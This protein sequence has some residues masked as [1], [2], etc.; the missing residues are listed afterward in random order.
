MEGIYFWEKGGIENAENIYTKK[1]TQKMDGEFIFGKRSR[2]WRE[3]IFGK[4]AVQKM[5]RIY[6]LEK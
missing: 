2:K 1:E 6:F 4:K 3:Y 5:E